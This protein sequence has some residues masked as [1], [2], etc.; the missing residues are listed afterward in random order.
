M[1]PAEAWSLTAILVAPL[2]AREDRIRAQ[3]FRAWYR[4]RV[5]DLFR[6]VDVVLAPATPYSAPPIGAP[7]TTTVDGVEVLTRAHLGVFTQPLSFIGLPV[8]A[9]P[10]AGAGRL[11]LGVQLIA[12]PFQERALFRVASRLEAEGVVA[13]P[14]AR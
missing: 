14:V 4:A 11:P 3:R 13:A 1:G 2:A 6:D 12:A 10:V 5:R 8:L 9:V 7:R